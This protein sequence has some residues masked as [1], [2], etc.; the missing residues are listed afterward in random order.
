MPRPGRKYS[1]KALTSAETASARRKL[2][3]TVVGIDRSLPA[4]VLSQGQW[5]TSPEGKQVWRLALQSSGAEALRLRFADFHAG[6][7]QV[8][9]FGS[10]TDGSAATLGPYTGDGL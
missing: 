5:S 6:A 7:G 9:I 10:V 4:D 3:L 2:G 1:L 8:W